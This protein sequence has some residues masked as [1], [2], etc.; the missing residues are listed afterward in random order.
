VTNVY[1]FNCRRRSRCKLIAYRARAVQELILFCRSINWG[2]EEY[3]AND[4][5]KLPEGVLMTPIEHVVDLLT[6]K[7]CSNYNEV[8]S[9][10]KSYFV[11][12]YRENTDNFA[13]NIQIGK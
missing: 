8:I 1:I 2:V 11:K 10:Q 12:W 13:H 6:S 9:Q 4:R 7:K 3:E 5:A